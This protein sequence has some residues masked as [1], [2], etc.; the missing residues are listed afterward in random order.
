[1]KA[2]APL[3]VGILLAINGGAVARPLDDVVKSGRITIFVYKNYQPYS[4]EESGRM[5][6]IDVDIAGEI[7]SNLGVELELLVREADESVDDDLRVNVWKGD[8]VSHKAADIMLHVPYD[9]TLE[10]RS[11]S[12]AILFNPY[13]DEEVAVAYDAEKLENV[14]TFGRF[15]T[16]P[17][18]VEVDT[19]G[20]FFLSNA[21]RG[22]L[23]QSIRRGRY[24]M[25]AVSTLEKGEAPALMASRAQAEWV[26]NRNPDKNIKIAQP[27]TP[28]I[29]RSHWPIGMA[30]RHDSRDL[31]YK[32]GDIITQLRES[33]KLADIFA[34]YGV[35]YIEPKVE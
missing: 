1:M 5:T 26:K 9:R 20:D 30:V 23:H 16:N 14:E 27:P 12:M 22:Q 7:A 19:V 33:G 8:L 15:V 2:L 13:F 29:V 24:F 11:E 3:L 25:D 10:I 34:R 28:G 17:I 4:W 18:A 21:F 6:G 35:T 31:G 32:A